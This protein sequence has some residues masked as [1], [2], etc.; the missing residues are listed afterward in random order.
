MTAIIPHSSRFV[1][2]YND[3][4]TDSHMVFSWDAKNYK[5]FMN[6]C[7]NNKLVML[8]GNML[9]THY[10]LR[11]WVVSDDK[12]QVLYY[13]SSQEVGIRQVLRKLY[14]GW[15]IKTVKDA[16]KIVNPPKK[17]AAEVLCGK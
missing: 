10:I 12:D 16:E 4:F 14:Q 15:S 8:E 3:V 11:W 1:V 17:T 5:D 9:N 2:V 13:I 7:R 6:E